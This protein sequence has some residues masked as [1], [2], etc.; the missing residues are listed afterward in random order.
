MWNPRRPLDVRRGMRPRGVRTLIKTSPAIPRLAHSWTS[1]CSTRPIPNIRVGASFFLRRAGP[2]LEEHLLMGVL[3][4]LI[5]HGTN[6]AEQ[7][8]WGPLREEEG[9]TCTQ[10]QPLRVERR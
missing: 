5:L 10:V 8:M 1:E 6:H 7:K 4:P 2:V 3:E 9:V